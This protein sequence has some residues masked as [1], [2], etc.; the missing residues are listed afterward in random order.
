ME[1]KDGWVT[2]HSFGI[3]IGQFV[4]FVLG[5]AG[6][7]VRDD[8]GLAGKYDMRIVKQAS[9]GARTPPTPEASA[10]EIADQLGLQLKPSKGLVE[11]LVIDHVGRPSPN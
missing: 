6:H 3:S 2:T 4:S 1:L 11:T 10:G 5:K 7:P 8:T 9:A